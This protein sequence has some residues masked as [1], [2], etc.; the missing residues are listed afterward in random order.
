MENDDRYLSRRAQ[1][2]RYNS[3]VRTIERWGEAGEL[4]A[5]YELGGRKFRRLSDLQNWER[6][7]AA[8]AASKAAEIRQKRE[9]AEEAA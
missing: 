1:A 4:P 7:R 2:E 6:E 8:V 5:E 9:R 3:S